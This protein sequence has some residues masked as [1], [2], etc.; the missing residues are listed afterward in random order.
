MSVSSTQGKAPSL[1]L[2][3]SEP[4]CSLAV[5]YFQPFQARA[6]SSFFLFLKSYLRDTGGR[7]RP[8]FFLSHN[9]VNLNNTAPQRQKER[10]HERR[11][12]LSLNF[13]AAV[14]T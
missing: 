4:C 2:I 7:P 13:D 6:I 14:M 11:A 9:N 1:P 5:T 8:Y 10:L 3:I 12:I